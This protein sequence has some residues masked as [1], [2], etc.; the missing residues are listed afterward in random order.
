MTLTV[1]DAVPA[2]APAMAR[3]KQSG[4]RSAYRGIIQ[5]ATL[6]A[7]D[8]A[9][10]AADFTRWIDE[11][12]AG[13]TCLVAV[14][15]SGLVGYAFCGPYRWDELP[16]AGEVYAIYVDPAAWGSGAGRALLTAAEERL[17]AAGHAEAALWVLEGNQRGRGFYEAVGWHTD[18]A[19]DQRCEAGDAPEVRYRR[20]LAR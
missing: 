3:V 5:E 9:T 13:S 15:S 6:A 8:V 1:R 16:G 14:S 17:R 12:A 20:S 2:D 19:V 18:G 4:W 7:M 10:I 11:P